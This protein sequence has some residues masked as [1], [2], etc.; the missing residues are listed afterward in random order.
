MATKTKTINYLN[1]LA[2]NKNKLSV[3]LKEKGVSAKPNEK[4]ESLV[5][6]VSLIQSGVEYGEWFPIISTDSFT[7]SKIPFLP[8]KIG[9]SCEALFSNRIVA[10]NTVHIALLNTELTEDT[11]NLYQLNSSNES[12]F[13]TDS[14]E[15][16]ITLTKDADNTYSITVS[17]A[18]HNQT[19]ENKFLFRGGLEHMW[20]VSSKEWIL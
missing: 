7:I 20:V 18:T 9:I 4:L 11:T 12:I 10:P 3:I 2:E 6:K 8:S 13:N 15:A 17:F 5:D 1:A 19:S 16:E 14:G